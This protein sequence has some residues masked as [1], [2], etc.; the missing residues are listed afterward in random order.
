MILIRIEMHRRVLRAI[1][2]TSIVM[3]A[4]SCASISY[5]VLHHFYGESHAT[6]FSSTRTISI[7]NYGQWVYI[8]AGSTPHLYSVSD[9]GYLPRE[10]AWELN[11]VPAE[12][13]ENRQQAEGEHTPPAVWGEPSSMF[14]LKLSDEIW[15]A[16]QETEGPVTISETT[17]SETETEPI[18][19]API[20]SIIGITAGV[21]VITAVWVGHRHPWGDAASTLFE[22]GLTNMTVR[23][24]KIFGEILK[25]EEF[26]IP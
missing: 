3:I 8:G 24:V 16:A 6:T 21:I 14:N 7:E 15:D 18:D 2:A 20:S 26:T 25:L 13:V 23:D 4:L 19:V 1:V 11:L 22:H 5:S 10:D 9:V 12:N 17:T